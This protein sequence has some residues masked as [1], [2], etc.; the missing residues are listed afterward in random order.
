MRGC[1][2]AALLLHS[3]QPSVSDGFLSHVGQSL[4]QARFG[5]ITVHVSGPDAEVVA[6]R[7]LEDFTF[8]FVFGHLALGH[9]LLRHRLRAKFVIISGASG[10][11][12]KR[13]NQQRE[14]A[15]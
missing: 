7:A 11:I 15:H 3:E 12:G 13:E 2:D 5:Q 14:K 4:A 6:H 10:K 9:A 8:P 1:S